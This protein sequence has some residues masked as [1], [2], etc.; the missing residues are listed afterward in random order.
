MRSTN[1]CTRRAKIY[2]H[3]P[4]TSGATKYLSMT[5]A[6]FFAS[7]AYALGPTLG[8]A[9]KVVVTEI[10]S[11]TQDPM[12]KHCHFRLSSNQAKFFL[13][14]AAVVTQSEIHDHYDILPCYV[15]GTAEFRG[16]SATW[17]IREGGTGSITLWNGDIFIIVDDKQR[18]SLDSQKIGNGQASIT[19][20]Y[21]STNGWRWVGW[22]YLQ[23]QPLRDTSS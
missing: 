15:R 22:R 18:G 11:D 2:T 13:N 12:A 4:M 23:H 1:F 7:L 10:G 9:T 16:I 19:Q 8:P 5:A 20:S 6:L 14:H 21:A 3:G 17:E